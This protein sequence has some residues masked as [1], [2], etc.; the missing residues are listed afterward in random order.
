MITVNY[1]RKLQ[2]G[3]V[4]A[5]NGK[6][7]ESLPLPIGGLISNL[8]SSAVQKKT[9]TM[10]GIAR[11]MGVNQGIDPF[12]TLSFMALPVI[13]KIRLTDKGLLDVEKIQ[14]IRQG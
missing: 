1:L 14:L 13:P 10:I 5:S 4:I 7:I 8:S 6:V 9:K 2:G 11:E 3:Y 12:I